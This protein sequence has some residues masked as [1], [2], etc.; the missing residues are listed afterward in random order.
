MINTA[1]YQAGKWMK[2]VKKRDEDC[3]ALEIL[4]LNTSHWESQ[5]NIIMG[6]KPILMKVQQNFLSI[7]L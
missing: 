4:P 2:E 1:A 5:E 7:F 3:N 6:Y